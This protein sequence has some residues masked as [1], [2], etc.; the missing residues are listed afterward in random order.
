M[1]D[2]NVIGIWSNFNDPWKIQTGARETVFADCLEYRTSARIA[3]SKV[4]TYVMR[5]TKRAKS[6]RRRRIVASSH[7]SGAQNTLIQSGQFLAHV[8]KSEYR[9]ASVLRVL[10]AI[11]FLSLSRFMRTWQN[12]VLKRGERREDEK[13]HS[14]SLV[15]SSFSSSSYMIFSRFCETILCRDLMAFRHVL[16]IEPERR[17]ESRA[18]RANNERGWTGQIG[19]KGHETHFCSHTKWILELPL[20]FPLSA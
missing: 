13:S 19:V 20:F 11:F 8:S 17:S 1:H 2:L 5:R 14:S 3:I 4:M 7:P 12:F 15:A 6:K 10:L 16:V 18:M 9:A